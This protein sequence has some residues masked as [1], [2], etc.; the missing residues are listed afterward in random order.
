MKAI[1]DLHIKNMIK[2]EALKRKDN[3]Y[4]HSSAI[5]QKNKTL[6]SYEDIYKKETRSPH[7]SIK[8]PPKMNYSMLGSP[9]QDASN[10][11]KFIEDTS[12]TKAAIFRRLYDHKSKLK[13]KSELSDRIQTKKS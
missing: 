3:S 10:L 1:Q 9:Q 11:S 6:S 2:E 4:E 8:Y 5:R 7:H 12:D 13:N